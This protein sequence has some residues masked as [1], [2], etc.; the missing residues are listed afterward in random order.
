MIAANAV[1]AAIWYIAKLLDSANSAIE[2]IRFGRKTVAARIPQV[3][4]AIGPIHFSRV[5]GPI[6]FVNSGVVIAAP[7]C[8]VASSSPA[9]TAPPRRLPAYGAAIP[10]GTS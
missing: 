8:E 1:L 5:S 10:S 2:T 4:T 7:A 6:F 9:A 3:R